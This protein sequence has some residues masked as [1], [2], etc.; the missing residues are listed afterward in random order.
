MKQ[1]VQKLKNGKLQVLE[2]PDPV[3]SKGKILVQNYYSVIS[4]GTEG[5]TVSTARKSLIGKAKER[6]EQVK[7][8][9]DVL[10]K[11]GPTQTYRAVMK[12]LDSYSPLGYST[13]GKVIDVAPDVQ[14]FSP[15]DLVA[16]AGVGYANHAELIAVPTNLC[17][18]LPDQA[19]LDQAAYNTI[20]AIAMQGVRQSEL[21]L[22]ETCAV[23]GLGL[24]G[25][26][27][28]L[29]L[30]AA[31]IK[32][33]GIDISP[34]VVDI[35]KE[36]CVDIGFANN[37]PG[38]VESIINYGDGH[39]MDAVIITAATSSTEPINLAGQILRRKGRVVIVGNVPTGFNRETYYRKELDLRMSTSYGPGRYDPHYEE[40]GIDY[41]YSYVRWTEKRNMQA[42]QELIHSGKIDLGYLSKHTYDIHEAPEAFDTILDG[43]KLSLGVL[44][45]YDA[46][47]IELKKKVQ[48]KDEGLVK[49][50]RV[51]VAFI[52]AGSY[53]MNNL[54]PNLSGNNIVLSGVLTSSGTSSRSVAERYGF[55]FCTSNEKDIL[56]KKEINTLFI[57]TRHDSH[58]DYV[59]KG[60]QAGKNVFVEKPLCLNENELEEI[61]AAIS[62]SDNKR[63]MV[64]FNRRFSPLTDILKKNFSAGP[65]SIIYRINA[66]S[67]PADSW[68]QISDIGGGRIIGEACH[69]IDFCTY[70]NGSLPVEVFATAME[71]PNNTEDTVNISLRFANGSIGTV[72]YYANGSGNMRK[73]YV[74][75]YKDNITGVL[76]DF[77]ELKIYRGKGSLK[78]KL[79][80]QNKGQVEMINSFTKTILGG[81]P[82]PIPF[83]EIYAVMKATFKAVES[84]RTKQ[85]FSI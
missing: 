40:M 74:E 67:M 47:D 78:K 80:A 45:K 22:G 81:D 41:P 30:K 11:Q 76:N 21:R 27:T 12:K 26:I 17:V 46:N 15:G 61:Q 65:M 42:F 39:G 77:K 20:G 69:F 82:S 66:G 73:E 71:D 68:M 33:V 62:K 19:H 4:S 16:C 49:T 24:I 1:L 9:I 84:I 18:K 83:D 44:I 70:M 59:I 6:P 52:G 34:Q 29:I 55:D 54:L 37:D 43:S 25:Q 14:E 7:Q 36:H 51:N 79:L 58:A 85:V 48:L 5:S 8:V 38:M 32:V 63:L 53:A 50:D 10:K 35:A 60:I 56:D 31:G 13:A 57:A 3:L 2:V 28:S 23:I 75:V 64:G 72:S